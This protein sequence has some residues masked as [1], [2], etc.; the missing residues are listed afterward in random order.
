MATG[1]P[2][3]GVTMGDPAGIGP[4]VTL[5]AVADNRV[6]DAATAVILGDYNH[7]TA[8]AEQYAID[9]DLRRIDEVDDATADA[10]VDVM[11]FDNVDAFEHGDLRADNGRASLEYVDQSIDLAVAGEVDGLCNGPIHK[12]AIGMAGSEY[13]G[14]TDM[15]VDRTD[16][17][18]H[19][20]L[21]TD[22]EIYVTHLSIHVPLS[23]AIDRVTEANVLDAIRVTQE[24]LPEAGLEDPSIGVAGINPHAGD[25]G[26]IGTL[27]DEE[28]AP[29]VQR[30]REEGIDA[31]GPL[32]PDS[33]FNRAL[34][35][36]FDCMM[37]MYHDQGHIPLFVNS[38]VDG[39]GVKATALILGL[40]FVRAT[41]LHGTAYDI[42]GRGIASPESMIAGIALAA[43]VVRHRS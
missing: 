34:D 28:I 42:A 39:G 30:A 9:V 4:E 2:V 20:A 43:K 33:A 5:K 16:T 21:L 31:T 29:A 35:G 32:P 41:T 36:D 10:P 25:G 3:I 27:D 26:V 38:H 18:H 23:E 13:A 37:A 12:Q 11:D 7:L 40:P 17:E 6:R 19:T 22:G 15:M 8:L 1:Q 24:K 14:H